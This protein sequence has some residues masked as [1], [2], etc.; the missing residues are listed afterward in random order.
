MAGEISIYISLE[1]INED[2]KE[3]R[4]AEVTAAMKDPVTGIK[5]K[6]KRYFLKAYARCFT[7]II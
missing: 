2:F 3:T 6:D 7:G 5:L 1:F 4:L